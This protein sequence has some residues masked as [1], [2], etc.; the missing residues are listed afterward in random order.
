MVVLDGNFVLD[1]GSGT[2]DPYIYIQVSIKSFPDYNHLLQDNYC[3][4]NANIY[5]Q[6]TTEITPT[7]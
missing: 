4:W 7:F 2:D 3:T 1:C 5:I 6:D